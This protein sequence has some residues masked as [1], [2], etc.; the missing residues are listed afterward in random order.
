MKS[1]NTKVNRQNPGYE[2]RQTSKAITLFDFRMFKRMSCDRDPA[3]QRFKKMASCSEQT[4]TSNLN[5]IW[6]FLSPKFSFLKISPPGNYIFETPCRDY[7]QHSYISRFAKYQ[8]Y[9]INLTEV[10]I[11]CLYLGNFFQVADGF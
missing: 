3:H 4:R 5:S 2:T 9:T 1:I 6:H 11:C 7:M 8:V 10:I